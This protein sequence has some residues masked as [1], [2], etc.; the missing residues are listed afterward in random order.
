MTKWL[1]ELLWITCVPFVQ[2]ASNIVFNLLIYIDI[3]KTPKKPKNVHKFFSGAKKPAD[4]AGFFMPARWPFQSIG[5]ATKK[6]N[7]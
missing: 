2:K 7:A 6:A 5:S 1:S 4:I 3:L